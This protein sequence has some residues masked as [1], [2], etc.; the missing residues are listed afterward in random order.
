MQIQ[1]VN[2]IQSNTSSTGIIRFV[3]RLL[4]R[5]NHMSE[6]P[7]VPDGV[8]VRALIEE[9]TRIEE[10]IYRGDYMENLEKLVRIDESITRI[11]RENGKELVFP[12]DERVAL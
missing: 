4:E 5:N 9:R 7:V 1:E 11:Y 12:K 6:T 3:K 2:N 8:Y 10:N